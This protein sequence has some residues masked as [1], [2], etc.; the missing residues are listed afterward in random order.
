MATRVPILPPE[1][2]TKIYSY[3]GVEPWKTMVMMIYNTLSPYFSKIYDIDVDSGLYSTRLEISLITLAA[4]IL[5]EILEKLENRFH[6][7]FKI[8]TRRKISQRETPEVLL[9]EPRYVFRSEKR[10]KR[11]WRCQIRFIFTSST[12]HKTTINPT[13]GF[14]R[15]QTEDWKYFMIKGKPPHISEISRRRFDQL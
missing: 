13:I 6:T 3:M 12:P 15:Y 1:I 11:G 14:V 10:V 9:V 5:E 8:Q 7:K 2:R 4:D